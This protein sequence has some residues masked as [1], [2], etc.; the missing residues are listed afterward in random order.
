MWLPIIA[1]VVDYST[2][3][4]YNASILGLFGCSLY[5]SVPLQGIPQNALYPLIKPWDMFFGDRPAT[6]CPIWV[7][8]V[9]LFFIEMPFWSHTL[10]DCCEG[11]YQ[12]WL[13][14][15]AE[16]PEFLLRGLACNDLPCD[17]R[18]L[19]IFMWG[20]PRGHFAT[21]HHENTIDRVPSSKCCHQNAG[22]L[23]CFSII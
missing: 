10:P 17:R 19:R 11:L 8:I 9:W 20:G 2:L 5:K 7:K 15:N 12:F 23:L 16:G 18:W 21:R 6:T 1:A 3:S 14:W 22:R 4:Y 13:P